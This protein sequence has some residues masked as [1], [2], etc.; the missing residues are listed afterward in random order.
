MPQVDD[1]AV[2]FLEFV[3]LLL[4]VEPVDGEGDIIHHAAL[5]IDG[6]YGRIGGVDG[7]GVGFVVGLG[8]ADHAEGEVSDADILPDEVLHADLLARV[9]AESGRLRIGRHLHAGAR[10]TDLIAEQGLG[11]VFRQH[12]HL[13]ALPDIFLVDEAAVEDL[14]LVHLLAG[15][16]VAFDAAGEVFLAVADRGARAHGGDDLVHVVREDFAGGQVHITLVVIDSAAFLQAVVGLGRA[17]AAHLHDVGGD[18]L[19]AAHE[20]V[21]Q[22]VA[23]TQQHNE[24]EDAPGHRKAREGGAE[25][26]APEAFPYFSEQV[27]HFMM[28]LV[29]NT[30]A[31]CSRLSS[32]CPMM[33]SLM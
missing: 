15:G 13:A 16:E 10:V 32:I 17:A 31:R 3:A 12:H 22:A 23:G 6:A 33:P 18:A 24:H 11:T 14:D 29:P 2:L 1:G 25:L 21:H 7:V 20:G 9:R 28:V 8:D 19:P 5:S 4:R 26:V 30:E 27:S